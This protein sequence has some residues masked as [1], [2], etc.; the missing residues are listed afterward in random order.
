MY[1]A[2]QKLHVK[3][4]VSLCYFRWCYF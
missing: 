3:R 2:R 1:N 4:A